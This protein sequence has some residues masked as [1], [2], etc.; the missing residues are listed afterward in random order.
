MASFTAFGPGT[1]EI[2]DTGS[3][4]DFAGEV[5]GGS[6]THTYEEIGESRT[7][8][9]GSVRAATRK[10][11]DG[12]SFTV[13]NDLTAAGLYSTLFNGDGTD[14]SFTYTPN[15]A[16]GAAWAGTITLALPESVGADEF[17]APIVSTVELAGVGAFTFTPETATP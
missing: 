15:T 11:T 12:L 3:E 13:E 7:M 16:G 1:I 10:R 9:D 8:L 5:L 6:V 2:G 4:V 14:K 17:G